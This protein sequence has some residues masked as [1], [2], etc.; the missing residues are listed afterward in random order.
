MP[1]FVVSDEIKKLIAF[2]QN[3]TAENKEL[4]RPFSPGGLAA[5]LR[6]PQASAEVQ[7]LTTEEEIRLANE[8]FQQQMTDSMGARLHG[9][10]EL[11]CYQPVRPGDVITV[12]IKV[13][14]MRKRQGSKLGKMV[15]VTF[16]LT[17]KNQRQELVAKCRQMLIGY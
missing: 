3:R 1:P 4:L 8:Q 2:Q 16:E 15:F 17:Y 7:Q 14:N 10:T 6:I 11:E 12:T 9:G 13:A 5:R